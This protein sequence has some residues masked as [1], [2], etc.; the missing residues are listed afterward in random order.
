MI[1]IVR[2]ELADALRN[3]WVV[4]YAGLLAVLGLVA[5]WAGLRGSEG[6]ALQ[7]YGR[8]T[9]TL[10]NLCLFLA[11]L[12]SLV[13]GASAIASE[14]DRGTL[15][16]LLAQP[17]TRRELLVAKYAALLLALAGAT[18]AGFAPAGLAIA[19]RAGWASLLH[20]LVFPALAIL[21]V[22]AMLALGLALSVRAGSGVIALGWAVFVWFAYVL[23][24]DLVLLGVLVGAGID[25]AVL[26]VL[27]L[28]N[29]V[30]AGRVLVVLA[31][32]PDLYLLGPAGAWML[33]TFG[34]AGTA[35]LLAGSLVTWAAAGLLA[36]S[37]WFRLEREPDE[38]ETIECHAC[39]RPG[40]GLGRAE[41]PTTLAS[42]AATEA[43][44]LG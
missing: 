43:A 14:R 34:K 25:P 12:V 39:S 8:T 21:L 4:G 23:L 15:D 41:C 1:A 38:R 31:L 35:A 9:A 22:A 20:F 13:L 3:R 42:G 17:I 5:A 19:A 10:T 37:W 27:L 40:D 24:Y 29:P 30:D 7:T 16:Y 28:A 2:K 11:P 33:G 44:P 6:L 36:A 32:E 26:A 18:L